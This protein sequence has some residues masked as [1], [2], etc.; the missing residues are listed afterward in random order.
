MELSDRVRIR[1]EELNLTQDELA[2]KMGYASRVS[3]NKIENGRPVSQ[4]IIVKLAAALDVTPSYLMGWTEDSPQREDIVSEITDRLSAL[5]PE[6]QEQVLRF[7]EFL[8]T[9]E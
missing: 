1:R 3:V 5:T 9:Q 7:A 4:K 8:K 6:Q 2:K